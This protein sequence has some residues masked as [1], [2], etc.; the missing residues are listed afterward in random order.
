M[1]FRN[2]IDL[3]DFFKTEMDCVKYLY[4]RRIK[5][6]IPCHYCGCNDSYLPKNNTRIRCR[7]CKSQYSVRVGTIFQDSNVPLR[8]WFIAMYIYLS[9]KKGISSCQLAKDITV[10][11]PTAWFMLH[12]LRHISKDFFH[13]EF[14]GITE[15]DEAYFGGKEGNKHTVN[16][17]KSV[18]TAVM[19]LVNRD[20]KQVRA[21]S[22]PNADKE[23]LLPK[24]GCNVKMGSTIVTDTYHAYKDL[25]NNYKHHTIKHSAK[26]YVRLDSRIAFKIHTNTIEGFWSQ[27]KRGIYGIYHWASKKHINNYLNEF[28]FRYNTKELADCER[29]DSFLLRVESKT[30]KYKNLIAGV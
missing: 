8:K 28:S 17:F 19:G 13:N 5:N 18:K 14:D 1:K 26:E 27:V 9:H 11:Q 25:K 15:V 22:I 29:F 21:I 12:R 24:I 6:N 3:M 4:N 10:S 16:K 7:K 2:L 20:T 30:L 23:N